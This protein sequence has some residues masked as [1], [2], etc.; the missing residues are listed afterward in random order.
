[1]LSLSLGINGWL[2]SACR[3]TPGPPIRATKLCRLSLVPTKL[4]LKGPTHK[5]Q[6]DDP[7][8]DPPRSPSAPRV[9][10]QT[11]LLAW[12]QQLSAS[13]P[14]LEKGRLSPSMSAIE[15]YADTTRN[16]IVVRSFSKPDFG[17]GPQRL[18]SGITNDDGATRHRLI[19]GMTMAGSH[20][21]LHDCL[22]WQQSIATFLA[23]T[24]RPLV[25]RLQTA[26]GE[27]DS[28]S[29]GAI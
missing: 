26:T 13:G 14:D 28:M 11:A 21:E 23:T 1:V 24:K 7:G 12:V 19:R 8:S 9:Q 15:C 3:A 25:D 4:R 6:F 20:R 5:C 27:C 18:P 17:C 22:S 16:A 10:F 2:V 29:I